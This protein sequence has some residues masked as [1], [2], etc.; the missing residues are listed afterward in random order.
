MIEINKT[1]YFGIGIVIAPKTKY[2]KG[3]IIINF[4]VWE[5]NFNWGKD[6]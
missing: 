4:I 6:E 1:P 3:H 5:V 2:F